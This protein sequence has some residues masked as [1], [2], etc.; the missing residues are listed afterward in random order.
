MQ[1]INGIV[2]T[3]VLFCWQAVTSLIKCVNQTCQVVI[4]T[5]LKSVVLPSQENLCWACSWSPSNLS[6]PR[7]ENWPL[8][9]QRCHSPPHPPR[10]QSGGEKEAL[11]I[12]SGTFPGPWRGQTRSG[13]F[14]MRTV[15]I[16]CSPHL[17][18]SGSQ[19]P[20]QSLLPLVS[21]LPRQSLALTQYLAM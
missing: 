16:N 6:L 10:E 15:M 17:R 5:K 2:G 1:Y 20:R 8:G 21:L 11:A 7:A 3:M 19:T 9:W 12:M 18:G 13:G 14:V 4:K